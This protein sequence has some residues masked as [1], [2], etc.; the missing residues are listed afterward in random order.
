VPLPQ[1]PPT[2]PE[3]WLRGFAPFSHQDFSSQ[4]S[5]RDM[6]FLTATPF[7]LGPEELKHI[8][9]LFRLSSERSAACIK[10]ECQRVVTCASNYQAAVRSFEAAWRHLPDA[11]KHKLADEKLKLERLSSE[12]FATA[13]GQMKEMHAQ[14]QEVLSKWV[15]RN[16]KERP[17]RSLHDEPI[18]LEGFARM[19]FAVLQRLL[20]EYQRYQ[21]T[22]TATQ[23]VS[24]TSSWEAFQASAVMR[25]NGKGGSSVDFYRRAMRIAT[26][27]VRQEHPKTTMITNIVGGRDERA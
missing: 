2:I 20:H 13:Y 15:V 19:P 10:F 1:I 24:L 4:E 6:L 8:M 11:E 9:G 18:P 22:F 26:T 17:Y 5:F 16:V 25:A 3:E 27:G 23:N 7:Q 12:E 21:R 14:L